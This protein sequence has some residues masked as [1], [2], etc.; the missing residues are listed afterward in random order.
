MNLHDKSIQLVYLL[1]TVN[2]DLFSIGK[3]WQQLHTRV[4]LN[5]STNSPFTK[6]HLRT[7]FEPMQR[8]HITLQTV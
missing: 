4:Q 1:R 6:N 5:K 7:G 8:G 2:F 3:V